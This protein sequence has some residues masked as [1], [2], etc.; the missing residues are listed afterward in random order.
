ATKDILICVRENIW[1]RQENL[2]TLLPQFLADLNPDRLPP[3]PADD[4]A[5]LWRAV[6]N[7]SPDPVYWKDRALRYRGVTPSFLEYVGMK[8]A[9]E[10]LGKTDAEL[11]WCL[12]AEL[13]ALQ[14]GKICKDYL[15]TLLVHGIPRR[16]LMTSFPIHQ[17]GKIT[18][19]FG[20]FRTADEEEDQRQLELLGI[21]DHVTGLLGYRGMIMAGMEIEEEKR[22]ASTAKR[23]TWPSSCRSPRS[24]R[25]P[26]NTAPRSSRR[27][28]R[29]S[30]TASSSSDRF[31]AS[32]PTSAAASL[33][34]LARHASS[35]A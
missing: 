20:Y 22:T 13:A 35:T 18:G 19:V 27:S 11:G 2:N 15:A 17:R 3:S 6:W 31:P 33:S 1:E 14:K 5:A 32:P 21:R 28:S 23:I 30:A 7:F 34:A 24:R 12:Q 9:S 16:I 25:S 8:D 4:E 26:T 29:P 10:I